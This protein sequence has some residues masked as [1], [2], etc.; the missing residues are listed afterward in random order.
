MGVTKAQPRS[1]SADNS[2]TCINS[3]QGA[4][5]IDRALVRFMGEY[6]PDAKIATIAA[7]TIDLGLEC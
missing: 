4:Y 6:V 7:G 5:L 3:I 1:A 2:I